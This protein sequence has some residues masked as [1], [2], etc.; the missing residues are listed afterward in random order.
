MI[1][2]LFASVEVKVVR[3]LAY[4]PN[5]ISKIIESDILHHHQQQQEE[6]KEEGDTRNKSS[7]LIRTRFPPE[8][9]GYLHL[10]HAKAVCFNYAMARQFGGKFHMRMD[11][12]NPLKE[13]EEY[14]ASILEDVQWILS[15]AAYTGGDSTTTQSCPSPPWDGPVRATSAYFH[16]IEQCAQSLL[17]TGDAFIDSSTPEQIREYR[18]TLLQPGRDSPYKSSRS[19]ADNLQLFHEMKQ[20]QHPPGSHVVRAKINMSSPNINLRDPILYRILPISSPS[21]S[22]SSTNLQYQLLPM[23]DFSHPIADALEGITHSLCSLEFED[24]RPFY[25]WTLQN[26]YGRGIIESY[27]QKHMLQSPPPT[28]SFP[29]QIEFSRLNLKYV[30]P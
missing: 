17:E 15:T 18:G 11:D 12:T 5:F 26:L 14:V 22:V 2:V 21:S 3:S 28:F 20:G 6:Q 13:T 27:Q 16:I 23:Y 7:L 30:A 10:G 8:P 29:K 25:E 9:N 4:A 24:H 19:I 1:I